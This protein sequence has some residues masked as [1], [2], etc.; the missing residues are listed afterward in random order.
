LA[1]PNV[2]IHPCG[3]VRLLRW[4]VPVGQGLLE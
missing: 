3:T 2:K 1:V 4:N